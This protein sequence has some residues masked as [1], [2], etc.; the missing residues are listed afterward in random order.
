MRAIE[1]ITAIVVVALYRSVSR[2]PVRFKALSTTDH[3]SESLPFCYLG[4]SPEIQHLSEKKREKIFTAFTS[5]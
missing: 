5:E 4:M 1:D 2:N 3:H